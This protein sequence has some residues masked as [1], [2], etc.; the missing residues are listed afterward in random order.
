[1]W[2]LVLKHQQ[3]VETMPRKQDRYMAF[4]VGGDNGWQQL[5]AVVQACTDFANPT[6]YVVDGPFHALYR[7]IDA[8]STSAAVPGKKFAEDCPTAALREDQTGIGNC[9]LTSPQISFGLTRAKYGGVVLSISGW[10]TPQAV[11]TYL[12]PLMKLVKPAEFKVRFPVGDQGGL[13]EI[14][15][16]DAMQRLAAM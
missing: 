3:K 7:S 5:A 1:M 16:A 12:E 4:A 13:K 8:K 2:T 10:E 11:R 9:V 14:T 15:L 6:L